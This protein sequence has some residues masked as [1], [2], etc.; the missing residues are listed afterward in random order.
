MQIDNDLMRLN[1]LCGNLEEKPQLSQ[2]LCYM[3][4]PLGVQ[5]WNY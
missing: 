3:M 2:E 1:Y 4:L 5:A